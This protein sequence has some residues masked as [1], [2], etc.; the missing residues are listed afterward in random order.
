MGE[1]GPRQNPRL[2]LFASSEFQTPGSFRDHE[3]LS[4]DEDDEVKRVGQAASG[5]MFT[6]T[7]LVDKDADRRKYKSNMGSARSGSFGES[8]SKS[9]QRTNKSRGKSTGSN[10]RS[11]MRKFKGQASEYSRSNKMNKS[12][13]SQIYSNQS[14]SST[15]RQIIDRI[16]ANKD[17]KTSEIIR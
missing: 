16:I 2:N 9:G 7:S 3:H 17:G 8:R 14:N 11:L 10:E 4:G 1:R 5:T 13:A 15:S 6:P 12:R